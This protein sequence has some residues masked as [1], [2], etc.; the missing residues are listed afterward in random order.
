MSNW[1]KNPMS[2]SDFDFLLL[3]RSRKFYDRHYHLI[4]KACFLG[5]ERLEASR[6]TLLLWSMT[7]INFLLKNQTTIYHGKSQTFT[8]VGRTV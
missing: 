4:E 7:K 3:V 8:F 6:S 5:W 2:P 1:S